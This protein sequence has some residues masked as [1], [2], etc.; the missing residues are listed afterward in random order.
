MPEEKGALEGLGKIIPGAFYDLIA[1]VG[2]GIPLLAAVA[3][4]PHAGFCEIT[5]ANLVLLVGAGYVVGLVLT[6]LSML[7]AP[8]TSFR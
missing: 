4:D 7:L 6:P 2:S 3:W 8:F 1:R 5:V